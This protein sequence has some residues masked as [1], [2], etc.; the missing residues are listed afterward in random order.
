MPQK[1]PQEFHL[2]ITEE[3][4]QN[5]T[6]AVDV[7]ATS[8]QLSKQL[9]KQA[10]QKG[11]VWREDA[12]GIQR[13]RRGDSRVAAG[14]QLHVY[15]SAQILAQTV[16]TPTL[17]ADELDY[18][19]WCKPSGMWSQGSKW[20]DHCTL[21]RWIETHQPF[22]EKPQRN[23][24]VVH[25]L[26]KATQG[27]MI[28]AHSKKVARTFGKLFE[29]RNIEKH[30]RARVHGL[31]VEAPQTVTEAIDEKT[32]LST[33]TRISVD[34]EK[35]QSLL[36]VNLGTGRKHQIRKHLQFLGYPI[37]GDRLYGSPD[38]SVDLQLCAYRL[39]FECPIH[40]VK[41]CYE[42]PTHSQQHRIN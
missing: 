31:F 15:Y 5:S 14:M 33:F 38:K 39:Q 18:S 29:E 10:M 37:V 25:R 23:A 3:Q 20:G 19:V 24:F 27:L 13:I 17:I 35:Q 7:L 40:Q 16:A 41:R 6:K 4:L 8:T 26:D 2:K 22:S 21:H 11:A 30:Y 1:S 32:A 9:I 28:I 42:L 34:T 12:R 36:D